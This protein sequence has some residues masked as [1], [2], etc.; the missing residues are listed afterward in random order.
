MNK[1]KKHIISLL[2]LFTCVFSLG[3]IKTDTCYATSSPTIKFDSNGKVSLKDEKGQALK[4]KE[5]ALNDVLTQARTFVVFLSGIGSLTVIGCFILNFINLA[6][7][8]GNPEGRK[9]AING[10]IVCGIATAGLGSVTLIT[11]LFYNMIN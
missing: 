5:D 3:A 4:N 6:N 11:Q 8:K 9:K 1:I 7:S 2:I 10:L